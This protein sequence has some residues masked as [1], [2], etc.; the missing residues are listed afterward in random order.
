M[1][2]IVLIGRDTVKLMVMAPLFWI[3]AYC[4]PAALL[5][6]KLFGDGLHTN[7]VVSPGV[8]LTLTILRLNSVPEPVERRAASGRY[9]QSLNRAWSGIDNGSRNGPAGGGES[10]WLRR[11]RVEADYR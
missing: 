11:R 7:E 5:K 8:V 6:R 3:G 1:V 4:P 10:S 9:V 2:A